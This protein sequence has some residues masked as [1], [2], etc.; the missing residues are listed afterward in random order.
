MLDYFYEQR[1]WDPMREVTVALADVMHRD[2]PVAVATV[3][4][5][6]GTMLSAADARVHCDEPVTPTRQ[7]MGSGRH[8]GG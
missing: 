5:V 1:G 8:D 6:Q 7:E 4:E 2:E 3:A